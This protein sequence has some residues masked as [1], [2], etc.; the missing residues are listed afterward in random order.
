MKQ[1]LQALSK[2]ELFTQGFIDNYQSIVNAI[3]TKLENGDEVWEVGDLSPFSFAS[4]VS[5]WCL[6]QDFS[7]ENFQQIEKVN[8]NE[9]NGEFKFIWK[10]NFSWKNFI[11]KVKKENNRW[12]ISFLEGF[13]SI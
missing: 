3:N 6:C 9:E 8:L 11:F 1:N 7:S 2:S 10:D 12:K 5:P 4:D 13:D